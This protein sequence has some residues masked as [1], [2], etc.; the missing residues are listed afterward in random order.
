MKKPITLLLVLC[1]V[2]GMMPMTAFGDAEPVLNVKGYNITLK[3]SIYLKYAIQAENTDSVKMLLW[4]GPRDSYELGTQDKIL[5]SSSSEVVSGVECLVF[6]ENGLAMKQMT[7][8]IYARPVATVNGTNYYGEVVKYSILQ[9][10]YNKLG[11]TGTATT[12]TAFRDLLNSMLTFGA[13]AQRYLGYRTDSLADSAF[14]Q[15]K[16]EG[17]VLDD[18]F[19]AGLYQTG[20]DVQITAPSTNEDG[21][22]FNHWENS[23]GANIGTTAKL[24]ITVGNKN[25]TYTSVYAK[26]EEP[27]RPAFS[28]GLEIESDGEEATVISIGDCSDDFVVIPDTYENVPV[29]SIDASAFAGESFSTVFI[30]V[31]VESIG[32]RAFNNCTSLKDVYYEGTQAQWG[33]IVLGTYNE[34]L[35]AATIHYTSYGPAPVK[36]FTVTF[37]DDAGNVLKTE[38]VKQGESATPPTAPE[39]PGFT[40]TGWNGSYT[41]VTA[42]SEVIASYRQNAVGSLEVTF[43]DVN[44][45]VIATRSGIAVGGYAE[46]PVA[47]ARSGAT[48]MGWS[49]TYANVTKNETVRAVY[50]DSKNVLRV[51]STSGKVG[52]QVTVLIDLNGAVSTCAFDIQINYDPGLQ[53]V[54]YDGDLD[55]DVMVNANV[56]ENGILL[57]TSSTTNKVKQ[58]DVVELTFLVKNGDKPAL[59]IEIVANSVKEVV[60]GDVID[61]AYTFTNGVVVV[62]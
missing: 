13:N 12:N 20:N 31:S 6:V 5:E 25:E 24:N 38:Q 44:G 15:V 47:P 19:T 2:L 28:E 55:L 53:L 17:G 10:A 42:D 60:N 61:T 45:S 40:F 46:P 33:A 41:D 1:M 32:R 39:K 11:K 59:P 9:Y 35:K 16:V 62:Q 57:N 51:S 18:G 34:P 22:A 43:V 36:M 8:V 27:Q 4:N 30:P 29:T 37:K 21:L 48:F 58:R 7:D 56:I 52:D 23:A 50:S 3:D 54:T 26:G 49:G 14:F